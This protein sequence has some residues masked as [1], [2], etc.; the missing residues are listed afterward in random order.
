VQGNNHRA[1]AEQKIN[2]NKISLTQPVREKQYSSIE[3]YA[4][5]VEA[6]DATWKAIKC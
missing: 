4:K 3:T 2:M 6:A 1:K 5:P